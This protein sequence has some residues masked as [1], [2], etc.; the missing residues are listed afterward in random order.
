[1]PGYGIASFIGLGRETTWGTAV[2]ASR[3]FQALNESLA[4][5]RDRFELINMAGRYAEPDDMAGLRRIAGDVSFAGYPQILGDALYGTCGVWSQTTVLSGFL[6]SH[7]FTMAE[8]EA[9]SLNSLPG[10]TFEVFRDVTSSQQYSGMQFSQLQLGLAPNQE[11]RVQASMIGRGHT[12]I[13]KTTPTFPSSA[14]TPFA[15]D[16]VSIGV[17]GTATGRFEA[18]N[19]TINNN[20]E[21]VPTLNSSLLIRAIRRTGFAMIRIGGSMSFEDISEYLDFKNQTERQ[22]TLNL[23]RANSFSLAFDFPRVVYTSFPLGVGGR[24]RQV[25]SFEG[26]VLYHAG[27]ATAMKA[28]MVNIT[29]GY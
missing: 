22:I 12:D 6:H 13:A 5:S 14:A 24:E 8:T 16:T 23:T 25:I 29:S 27:S 2:A 15:F 3:Y 19:M 28:T 17:G 11:L 9:G 26:R 4:E 10:Y 21:S 1:M 18:F 7:V 20:L